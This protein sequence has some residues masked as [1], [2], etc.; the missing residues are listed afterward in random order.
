[1]Q[2][3]AQKHC[4]GSLVHL[5]LRNMCYLQLPR[6]TRCSCFAFPMLAASGNVL[7][8]GSTASQEHVPWLFLGQE[9]LRNRSI[10]TQ[11]KLDSW[12][13]FETLRH[14]SETFWNNSETCWKHS[15]CFRHVSEMLQTV[16]QCFR[17]ALEMFQNVSECF[18]HVSEMRQTVSQCFRNVSEM[19]QKV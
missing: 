16:S 5:E 18:R 2:Q 14:I 17:N 7:P 6:C 11:A 10:H 12:T 13:C 9:F 3:Q 4:A 1:M 15:E 8:L 19:F